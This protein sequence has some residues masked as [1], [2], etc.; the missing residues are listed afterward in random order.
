MS[1]DVLMKIKGSYKT[2]DEIAKHAHFKEDEISSMS[3]TDTLMN[4]KDSFKTDLEQISSMSTDALLEDEISNMST[5]EDFMNMKE[6]YKPEDEIASMSTED[7]MK[8]LST[9]ETKDDIEEEAVIP[10]ASVDD[11][12]Y[13]STAQIEADMMLQ[14]FRNQSGF[15]N[16]GFN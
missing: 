15:N 9:F 7:L 2:G 3:S 12:D 5:N 1:A 14:K 4:M 13:L 10:K 16:H 8:M 6:S 11:D